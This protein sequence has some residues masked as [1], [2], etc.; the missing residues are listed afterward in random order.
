MKYLLFSFLCCIVLIAD[1]QT[2]VIKWQ[3]SFGGTSFDFVS[4]SL[5]TLDGGGIVIGATNSVDSLVA[6]NHGGQDAWVVKVDADGVLQWQKCFGGSLSDNFLEILATSDGNYVLS[7]RSTSSDGDVSL[8]KGLDDYWILKIDGAGNILWEK[9]YG[10]SQSDIARGCVQAP[11]GSFYIT[12]SSSSTDGDVTGNHGLGDSWVIKLDSAGNLLWQKALGGSGVDVGWRIQSTADGGVLN[13]GTTASSNGDVISLNHGVLD[14]WIVK[15][16]SSGT[17]QWEKCYGGSAADEVKSIGL[18]NDGDFLVSG[19]SA[20]SDGDLTSNF[21]GDDIWIFEIDSLGIL[22]WQKSFGGSGEDWCLDSRQTASG[23]YLISGHSASADHDVSFN[24]GGTDVWIAKL[25]TAKN[26]IWE[27]SLGGSANE[28]GREFYE[29]AP[30]EYFLSAHSLSTDGDVTGN[31]GSYD[32]WVLRLTKDFNRITGKTYLDLNSNQLFDGIDI[33]LVN[34]KVAETSTGRI[35]FTDENGDYDLI[36]TNTGALNLAT[37]SIHYFSAQPAFYSL[38]FPVFALVDSLNDF[39][40][41]ST[42]TVSDLKVTLTP[43][44]LFRPGREAYY[45]IQ[46]TNVGT[47]FVAA[48]VKLMPDT[49]LTYDSASVAPATIATDTIS[50]SLGLLAPLQSGSFYVRLVVDSAAMVDSSLMTN[51]LIEP[52]AGDA[53]TTNNFDGWQSVITASYDPNNKLVNHEVLST[54]ELAT[55]PWLEYVINFQNTGNDTAF[56]IHVR[57]TLPSEL[58]MQTFELLSSSH[59]VALNYDN[60]TRLMD[61]GFDNILLPDSNTNEARSHG[62]V[63]FRIKPYTSLS[64]GT[65]I[66]NTAYIYFDFNAPVATNAAITAITTTSG[67]DAINLTETLLVYPNPTEDFMIIHIPGNALLDLVITDIA[68]RVVETYSNL[69]GQTLINTSAWKSGMY[70]ITAIAGDKKYCTKV[71]RN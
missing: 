23:E 66:R 9:T 48:T 36:V 46:Y 3:K 34:H 8:N 67:L 7:G 26:I 31:I 32:Y 24:H 13:V 16:D 22:Q 25:D 59:T 50:W 38:N 60:D 43:M 37:D 68:G 41:A 58:N 71:I 12:G 70:F 17:I 42:V 64:A 52:V 28:E 69:N 19:Y 57:D 33:P 61:F 29:I 2:P 10:G 40:F 55:S 63:H 4:W 20:S 1:A 62:Y 35:C 54:T 65:F 45:G 53:D 6:G 49:A 51:I 47:T 44:G 18:T 30:G 27:K 14:I 56:V 39:A 11:D 15:L 5:P 21:G